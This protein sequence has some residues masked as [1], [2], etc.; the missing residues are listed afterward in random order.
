MSRQNLFEKRLVF[1]VCN[2]TE[3]N[4]SML[5]KA[6]SVYSA[7][8]KKI[9]ALQRTSGEESASLHEILSWQLSRPL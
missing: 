6:Q 4:L 7:K 5:G 8:E 9:G 1:L 3:A 2:Y